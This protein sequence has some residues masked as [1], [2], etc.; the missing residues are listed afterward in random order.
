MLAR[1][2]L[3]YNTYANFTEQVLQ[4]VREI[5][6][7]EDMGQNS[8]LTADEYGRFADWLGLDEHAHLL[9]VA[10]G[11]GGPALH[12]ARRIGCRVSGVDVN[13]FGVA[14][15]ERAAATAGLGQRVRFRV[16]D[17]C[18]RLP[19]PDRK[20]DA[21]MCID[22][23][24]HFPDRL[25]T[26]REWWRVLRSGARAVFTDPVVIT[27]PV[28]NEE[29]AQRSSIG[30]FVFVPRSVNEEL[31]VKAGFK[32]VSQLDVTENAAL[33][34]RRW[35]EARERFR[36]ELVNIEGRER[37]D[38]VQQFLGAVHRLTSERRLSRIAYLVEK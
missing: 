14:T 4:Q 23:M 5:T 12:L 3:F 17:A 29:L 27:G 37:F 11:S 34:S 15:A 8:W 38:G 31:I 22:S 21:L 10:S 20:F 1:V 32:I 25:Q 35:R 2:D 13:A 33:V 6:Y 36:A 26:F 16:A 18:V 9:E 30:L 24:N 28:T 19:F 7:G